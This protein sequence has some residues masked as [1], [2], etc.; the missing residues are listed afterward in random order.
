MDD[1]LKYDIGNEK[2]QSVQQRAA[3]KNL[4]QCTKVWTS[5]LETVSILEKVNKF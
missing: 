3:V 4:G 2:V 1:S 5:D